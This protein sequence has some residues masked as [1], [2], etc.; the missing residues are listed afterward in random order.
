MPNAKI[1]DFWPKNLQ[2][3]HFRAYACPEEKFLWH[4]WGVGSVA[5]ILK[6]LT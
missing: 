6:S 2:L 1:M 3:A 4:I 5:N